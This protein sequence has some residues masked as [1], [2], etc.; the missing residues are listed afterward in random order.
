MLG[1]SFVPKWYN[2]DQREDSEMSSRTNW[3]LLFALLVG[4]YLLSNPRCQHGCRTVA[5][6]LVTASIGGFLS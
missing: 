5:E 4:V 2:T 3:R 6:H 1:F